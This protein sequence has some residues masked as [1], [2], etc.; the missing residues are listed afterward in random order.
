MQKLGIVVDNLDPDY[1][2]RVKVRILGVHTQKDSDNNY[3]ISDDDLPWLINGND[4]FHLPKLGD[5]VAINSDDNYSGFYLKN[6]YLNKDVL[7]YFKNNEGDY[8]NASVLM[9]DNCLGSDLDN[10]NKQINYR[11]GEY[12][13]VYYVDSKG[14]C[15]D[16]KTQVGESHIQIDSENNV[17]ISSG[18]NK[19]TINLNSNKIEIKA[20]SEITLDANKIKL[21]ENATDGILKSKEF[22]NLFNSHTH[23]TTNGVSAPPQIPL[24]TSILSNKIKVE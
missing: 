8:Q 24:N 15:I 3:I 5:I 22:I 4:K 16:Y 17:N 19:I 20:D 12:I 14:F 21:G 10:N 9:Y 7:E 11:D 23:Q 2:G 13:K 6:L 1:L 18:E